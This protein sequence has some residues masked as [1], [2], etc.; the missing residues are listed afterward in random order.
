MLVA[1][2]SLFL[3][4][5]FFHVTCVTNDTTHYNLYE[6]T[7][8]KYIHAFIIVIIMVL[9]GFL[10]INHCLRKLQVSQDQT[11]VGGQF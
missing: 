8:T 1:T 4:V 7:A 3:C 10:K 5:S 6:F 11:G 9:F 2:K